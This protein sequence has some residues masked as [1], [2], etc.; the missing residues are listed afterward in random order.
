MRA[1]VVIMIMAAL[2][3]CK[4][5][6]NTVPDFEYANHTKTFYGCEGEGWPSLPVRAGD[7]PFTAANTCGTIATG[8][9]HPH[10]MEFLGSIPKPATNI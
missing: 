4:Q 1:A 6:V 9:C 5:I 3:G 8:A 2:A 7:F 10:K